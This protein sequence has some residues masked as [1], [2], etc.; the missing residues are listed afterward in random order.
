M[1]EK[2]DWGPQQHD[3]T[4]AVLKRAAAQWGDR[5]FLDVL[6]T[7]YTFNDIDRESTRLA[8]GLRSL[9]VKPGQCVV[10]VLDNN[11]E[12]VTTWFAINKLGAIAVPTNTA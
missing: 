4:V 1:S 10:T 7:V 6:G 5:P 12:S 3:T 8:H 9:G 11:V 2:H